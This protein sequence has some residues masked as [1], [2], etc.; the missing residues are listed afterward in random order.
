MIIA[1]S[2]AIFATI[3]TESDK[4]IEWELGSRGPSNRNESLGSGRWFGN[5]RWFP[6]C[7]DDTNALITSAYFVL[8]II[9]HF[10]H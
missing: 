3:K 8:R 2:I 5:G 4:S 6:R 9:V 1:L 7:G 10:I